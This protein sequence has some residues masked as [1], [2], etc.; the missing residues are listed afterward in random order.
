[1][2]KIE[3]LS[4]KNPNPSNTDNTIHYSMT[5]LDKPLDI[6]T[7]D[8]MRLFGVTEIGI[9]NKLGI[10]YIIGERKYY[11]KETNYTII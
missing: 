1:M 10:L 9:S 8:K 2:S 6:L 11:E 7:H 3:N 4:K 5:K